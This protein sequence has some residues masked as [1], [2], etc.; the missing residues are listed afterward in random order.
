MHGMA[1]F[2]FLL[3]LFFNNLLFWLT[4]DGDTGYDVEH[5]TYHGF[6]AVQGVVKA[7]S[8]SNGKGQI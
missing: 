2:L 7:N 3:L 5:D 4:F 8:Q 1:R 6:T